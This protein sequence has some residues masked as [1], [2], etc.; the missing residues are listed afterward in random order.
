MDKY[1]N[2]IDTLV[3][4]SSSDK[5]HAN[6]L[7]YAVEN[8]CVNWDAVCKLFTCDNFDSLISDDHLIK[9]LQWFLSLKLQKPPGMWN[10]YSRMIRWE[11][12]QE[13]KWIQIYINEDNT[14][15]RILLE[16]SVDL[17]KIVKKYTSKVM[18]QKATKPGNN[19]VYFE[20]TLTVEDFIHAIFDSNVHQHLQGFIDNESEDDDEEKKKEGTVTFRYDF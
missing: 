18:I 1:R 16:G 8:D 3:Y 7:K 10:E 4:Y 2:F 14:I 9:K 6:D 5:S 13:R 15:D 17:N 11:H 12:K 20:E 19:F